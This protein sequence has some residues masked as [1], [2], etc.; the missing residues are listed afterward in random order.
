MVSALKY[1][2]KVIEYTSVD[3]IVKQTEFD[4][5]VKGPDQVHNGFRI[6]EKY[7]KDNKKEIITLPR[8]EGISSSELKAIIVNNNK[9][10]H[11]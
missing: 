6:A 5:F 2:D 9:N 10:M 7:C 11:K 1:V 4:I 8:T 3:E